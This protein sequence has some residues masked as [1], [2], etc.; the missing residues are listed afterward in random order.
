M[1][2]VTQTKVV[3]TNSKGDMVVRG[4]C[5]AACIASL[6]EMPITDVPNFETLYSIS[7]T[8]YYDVLSAWLKHLGFEIYNDSRFMCFHDDESKSQYKDEP[9]D[10]YYMVS[11]LSPRGIQ[12]VCI[13]QNG[14]LIHD[15]HPS[16][17]GITTEEYFETIVS[18]T[19]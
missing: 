7:D 2:P 18:L 16:R 9:K 12:H 11:G 4:N 14:K 15:P 5:L 10:K 3:V 8:Y 1:I 17:E 19:V 13:Y 6:L